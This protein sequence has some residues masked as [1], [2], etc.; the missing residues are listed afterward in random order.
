MVLLNPW[1]L[2]GNTFDTFVK[3]Y[4]SF[5]EFGSRFKSQPHREY[6]VQ[7]WCSLVQLNF[8]EGTD[9]TLQVITVFYKEVQLVLQP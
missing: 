8:Q 5:P 3:M 2:I 6:M 7:F 4:D 9:P 1:K